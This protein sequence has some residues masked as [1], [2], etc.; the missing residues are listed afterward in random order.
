MN[1]LQQP[2]SCCNEKPRVYSDFK[3]GKRFWGI[4]C[5]VCFKEVQPFPSREEAIE[6]WNEQFE[7]GG[8]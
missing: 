3:D 7:K 1:D 4:Y 2:H 5:T 6:T 8:T